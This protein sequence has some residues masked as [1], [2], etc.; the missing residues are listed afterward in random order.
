MIG[1]TGS[2]REGRAALPGGSSA[3]HLDPV[4][5]RE[6]RRLLRSPWLAVAFLGLHAA[7][8]LIS[9]VE[10]G[11]AALIVSPGRGGAIPSSEGLLAFIT[12]LAFGLVLP[13]AHFQSLGSELGAGKNA[14][15]LVTAGLSPWQIVGGRVLAATGLGAL[16]LISIL[17]YWLLRYFL[18]GFELIGFLG[19]M[20]HWLFSNLSMNA[21]VIG[22]SAYGS[23]V[24]RSALI[25]GCLIVRQAVETP[26]LIGAGGLVGPA[27]DGI[28]AWMGSALVALLFAIAGCQVGVARMKPVWRPGTVPDSSLVLV[29]LLLF[30]PIIHSVAFGLG[31]VITGLLILLLLIYAFYRISPFPLR[32]KR[33]KA[34]PPATPL[35]S[36]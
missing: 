11:I 29:M 9:L 20:L 32:K 35:G 12:S 33:L 23:V 21:I 16:L 1:S 2:R 36:S 30:V 28:W 34:I 10:S 31:G 25:V 22:G 14:E 6:Y 17:P 19:M 15:L 27:V 18:G 3:D 5:V 4:L 8:L 26:Y 7:A 24:G 13:L